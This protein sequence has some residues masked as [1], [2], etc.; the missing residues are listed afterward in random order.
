MPPKPPG[1]NPEF[2]I[3]SKNAELYNFDHGFRSALTARPAI[4]CNW[5]KMLIPLTRNWFS[6]VFANFW[7]F[8]NVIFLSKTQHGHFMREGCA[9]SVQMRVVPRRPFWIQDAPPNPKVVVTNSF[10][11]NNKAQIVCKLSPRTCNFVFYRDSLSTLEMYPDCNFH[12][13]LI[14]N[15]WR[16][17]ESQTELRGRCANMG[18]PDFP[19]LSHH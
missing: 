12:A 8:Q 10:Q 1:P 2:S 18:K 6:T 17:S 11:S 9:F 19:M 4:N 13:F 14:F 16:P 3:F 5:F 7:F 15:F